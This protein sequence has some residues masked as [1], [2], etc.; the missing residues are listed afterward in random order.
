MELRN[1]IF[2]KLAFSRQGRQT[3]LALFGA[4]PNQEHWKNSAPVKAV[5]HIK[6]V[7]AQEVSVPFAMIGIY[8]I[9]S[10]TYYNECRLHK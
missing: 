10:E 3:L 4:Q 6:T 5:S 9:T 1:S 2:L 7:N 8:S